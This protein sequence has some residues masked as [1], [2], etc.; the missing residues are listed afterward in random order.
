VN[1]NGTG[2]RVIGTGTVVVVGGVVV[3]V[4]GGAVVVVVVVGGVVVVVGGVVVVVGGG[5]VV[6]VGGRVVV[7]VGGRGR[8]VFVG[9]VD[10]V[11]CVFVEVGGWAVGEGPEAGAPRG[12]GP[13]GNEAAEVFGDARV[14]GRLRNDGKP[15][16]MCGFVVGK[17][18]FVRVAGP[19]VGRGVFETTT[20]VLWSV[21][22]IVLGAGWLV[23]DGP[24]TKA[25]IPALTMTTAEMVIVQRQNDSSGLVSEVTVV[26][27]VAVMS[28]RA[29]RGPCPEG[30]LSIGTQPVPRRV[31]MGLGNKLAV[32]ADRVPCS[33]P[34]RS[35]RSAFDP[36]PPRP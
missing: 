17:R 35:H 28:H 6:V 4:G 25:A 9:K 12:G 34:T 3:V 15:A 33:R 26:L 27:V 1:G 7:V 32:P 22:A 30:S 19:G 20:G 24:P 2:G 31:L 23:P 5:A 29:R 14:K 10:V 13:N 8:V 11:G 36:R 18:G 21:G 16:S